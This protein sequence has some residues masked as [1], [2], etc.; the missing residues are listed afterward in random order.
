[1]ATMGKI[2]SESPYFA[3]P[4]RGPPAPARRSGRRE[5]KAIEEPD[6]IERT[7]GRADAA[8]T[9]SWEAGRSE[10]A[11]QELMAMKT[12]RHSK[13]LGRA[14]AQPMNA[15]KALAKEAKE[16]ST[17]PSRAEPKRRGS[18]R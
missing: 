10:A 9:S 12:K 11:G 4:D 2:I 15:L 6:A 16:V 13:S 14:K 7:G 18:P 8:A 3:P 5:A 17:R 1:M